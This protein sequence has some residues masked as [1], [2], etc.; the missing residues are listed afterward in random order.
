MSNKIDIETVKEY[1]N[2]RP[3]NIRHSEKP[4]GSFEYFQEVADRKYFVEPHILRFADFYDW[5]GKKVLEIGCGLGTAAVEFAKAGAK[6]TAVDLSDKSLALAKQNAEV[7]NLKIK[8]YN[9]NVEELSKT[10]PVQKYD[11][12]YSFG[13]L[14][15]TPHPARAYK[16]L[17]KYCDEET[18][19]KIMLYHRWS[20]KVFWILLK[21]GKG[22]FWKMDELVA[23]Y[24]EAQCGCPVTFVYS[25][26]KIK[27]M[28]FFYG[29]NVTNMWVDH[30]FPYS[31]PEYKQHIYKK[32]W[33]FRCL[34]E[35]LF[36][37][38]EKRFGWHLCITAKSWVHK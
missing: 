32:V 7:R 38:L 35:F 23:R 34:P 31:I 9:A 11:L 5:K 16:E 14:H 33:Y 37:F 13:V 3:C 27:K 24:S 2:D 19:L 26:K 6:V 29:F 28:L 21:Y 12:I 20:W 36:R 25:K 22:A 15:H 8:F 30:I 18:V 17:N 10:V 1:W 4:I